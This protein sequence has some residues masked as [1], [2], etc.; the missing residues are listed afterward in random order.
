MCL[1]LAKE[2]NAAV[3]QNKIE[4]AVLN[5]PHGWGYVIPMKGDK[6]ASGR[7]FDPDGTKPDDILKFLEETMTEKVYLHLRYTTAGINDIKNCHPFCVL[8]KSVD[9]QDMFMMHNGTLHKY[10]NNTL[11]SSDTRIF[12]D[13]VVIPL[14]E[15][16][17]AYDGE[18]VL[19]DPLFED[20][21]KK[22]VEGSSKIVLIDE[23]GNDLKLGGVG[24]DFTDSTGKKWWVSNTYSFNPKHRT[25]TQQ[26]KVNDARVYNKE[27]NKWEAPP[28]VVNHFQGYK[29][30]E[31]ASSACPIPMDYA[32]THEEL[33]ATARKTIV[34]EWGLD[35][36][37]D[38]CSLSAEDFHGIVINYPDDAV[39]LILA[40][41]EELYTKGT[42]A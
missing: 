12:N 13:E 27:T 15:R 4:T 10:K 17:A 33:G 20:I 29:P 14:A 8:Q 42:S 39:L 7:F 3:D 40:L 23:H 37:Q 34:D 16:F 9:G 25:P 28:K 21:M 41:Q 1:I 31:P 18:P 22:Y 30:A 38:L 36:V 24:H 35:S 32:K 6:P 2:A 11:D 19:A 26:K 5:N